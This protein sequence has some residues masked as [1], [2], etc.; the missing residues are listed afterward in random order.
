M[1]I[2]SCTKA[3]IF[4]VRLLSGCFTK[5]LIFK[6]ARQLHWAATHLTFLRF[7]F[8]EDARKLLG[9]GAL[10]GWALTG[11][12][13]FCPFSTMVDIWT[14]DR[15]A[16][17]SEEG[18]TPMAA[19]QCCHESLMT[20]WRSAARSRQAHKSEFTWERYVVPTRLQSSKTALVVRLSQIAADS[21]REETPELESELRWV[22]CGLLTKSCTQSRAPRN[23]SSAIA[24]WFILVENFSWRV[25]GLRRTKAV[26][27]NTCIEI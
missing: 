23:S 2:W 10:T 3:W 1:T 26:S 4:E 13:S 20:R 9:P 14:A 22:K 5:A 25:A 8:S 7:A 24:S 6:A 18:R 17:T 11:T 21:V 12:K 15:G 16:Q 27:S 19:N